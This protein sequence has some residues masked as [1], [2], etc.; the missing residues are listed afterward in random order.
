MQESKIEARRE[1]ETEME[2][3]L[4]TKQN[5]NAP[6]ALTDPVFWGGFLGYFHIYPPLVEF[7]AYFFFSFN[8]G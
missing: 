7:G 2:K 3:K 4:K 5:K 8:T 6:L 1:G